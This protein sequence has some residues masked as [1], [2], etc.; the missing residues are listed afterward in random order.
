MS[1]LVE[2]TL[3][4]ALIGRFWTLARRAR[5]LTL[6]GDNGLVSPHG[7]LAC[8]RSLSG[9]HTPQQNGMIE[10]WFQTMKKHVSGQ[11]CFLSREDA[12]PGI[13]QWIERYNSFVAKNT[14]Q[15]DGF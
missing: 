6:R 5:L 1:K 14:I 15:V 10:R 11:S 13:G 12:R 2:A 9:P 8:S 4:D 7:A 3:E